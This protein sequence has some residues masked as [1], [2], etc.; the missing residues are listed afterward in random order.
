MTT[1]TTRKR[2]SLIRL[3][4]DGYT[5]ISLHARKL[6]ISREHEKKPIFKIIIIIRLL[7]CLWY[8]FRRSIT[9]KQAE[10]E[11]KSSSHDDDVAPAI[12]HWNSS[13]LCCW[14]KNDDRRLTHSPHY[15]KSIVFLSIAIHIG[16]MISCS[17]N[18]QRTM[19]LPWIIMTPSEH[20]WITNKLRP[21]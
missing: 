5:E 15:P 9:T 12:I 6:T 17:G 2:T 21:I 7:L 19:N 3:A 18:F 16:D 1:T 14:V 20:C 10:I 4:Q 8:T 11:S 13:K